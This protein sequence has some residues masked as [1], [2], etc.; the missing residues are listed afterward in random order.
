MRSLI[1]LELIVASS[2]LTSLSSIQLSQSVSCPTLCDPMDWSTPSFPVHH[3]LPELAQTHIHWVSDAIQPSH[4][5]LSPSPPAFNL[6][7]HQSLFKWVSSLYQ[8]AKVL[9]VQLQLSVLPMN[10]QDWFPLG[11][12]SLISLQSKGLSRVFSNITVQKHQFFAAQLSLWPNSH[13]HTW[14]LEKAQLWLDGLL[15]VKWCLCF[16]ICSLGWS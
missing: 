14:L 1:Y 11:L 7:Q 9:E 8:V 3:Q 6:F 12:T 10:I 5:L 15:S 2:I 4:P 13:I 16:L